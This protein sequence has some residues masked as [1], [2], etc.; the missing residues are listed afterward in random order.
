[1]LQPR[2]SAARRDSSSARP[3]STGSTPGIP[4]QMGQVCV[5]GAWPKRVEHPH[6]SLL[7]VSSSACVSRPMTGS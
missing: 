7:C 3:F 1:M 5:F 2:A 6:Q 4:R